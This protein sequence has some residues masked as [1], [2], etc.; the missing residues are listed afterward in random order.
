MSDDS[1]FREVDEELRS[2][3][4]RQA[5]A[6]YG[7]FVIAALVVFVIAVA[8]WRSWEWYTNAQAEQAGDAFLAAVELLEDDKRDEALVALRRI[9]AEG[10]DTY[11]VMARMRIASELA[12]TGETAEAVTLYDAVIADEAADAEQRA[13]ARIRAA[14]ILVDTGTLDDVRSRIGSLAGPGGP[15][16]HSARELLGLA[17]YKDEQLEE[18]YN[19]LVTVV[20]DAEAPQGVRDRTSMLLELIAA[21]GGPRREDTSVAEAPTILPP[22]EGTAQGAAATKT[23]TEGSGTPGAGTPGAGTL[24]AG[25]QGAGTPAVD[26]VSP[27]AEPATVDPTTV[28]PAT[29]EPVTVQPGTASG[30]AAAS[31]GGTAPEAA[32]PPADA[33]ATGGAAGATGTASE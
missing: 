2:D 12:E 33:S 17:Q 19:T 22:L 7:R 21:K 1:F 4:V 9:E 10:N 30:G 15:Y 32:S 5:W 27:T 18:A 3:R 20:D 25:T 8:G 14:I 24:G 13:L 28:E 11:R 31:E 26:G 6:R 23:A 16:R 29:A